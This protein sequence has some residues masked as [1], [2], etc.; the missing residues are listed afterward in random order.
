MTNNSN[1]FP[2]FPN[3]P[4]TVVLCGVGGQ[5]TI[6]AADLLARAAMEEGYEVK[7]SEIH[8]M[9]QR[10]GSVS[11]TVRFGA[12][13]SSMVC[14]PGQAD[15][16]VSFELVE[17]VRNLPLLPPTGYGIVN[18]VSIKPMSVLSGAARMPLAEELHNELAR[19]GDRVL[20][21]D[22]DAVACE[23]GNSRCANVALLAAVAPR[24]PIGEKAWKSAI[25]SRVP[26]KTLEAN[27]RAFDIG[28]ARTNDR[29]G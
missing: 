6:T 24:L 9:A 22:A 21:V 1:A 3:R 14:D 12:S 25:E 29:I 20:V 17:A 16:L 5:G 23:A 19:C 10:G 4:I 18:D 7:V 11:T 27:L 28:F 15:V 2:A 8:G 26:P 13:V